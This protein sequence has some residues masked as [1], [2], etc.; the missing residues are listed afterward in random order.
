MADKYAVQSAS[1]Y[2]PNDAYVPVSVDAPIIFIAPS[3]LAAGSG[4][5]W[6]AVTCP[7]NKYGGCIVWASLNGSA[8]HRVGKMIGQSK[9]GGLRA[10]L[11][12]SS[13]TLDT[14]STLSIS[15]SNVSNTTTNPASNTLSSVSQQ[16]VDTAHSLCYVGGEFLAY[17][18]ATFVQYANNGAPWYDLTYLRRGLYGSSKSGVAQGVSF[19]FLNDAIFKYRFN[20]ELVGSNIDFKLQA[21]NLVEGAYQNIADCTAYS[22]TVS[23]SGGIKATTDDV[24]NA[25][26]TAVSGLK[27]NAVLN[28]SITG[29]TAGTVGSVRLPSGTYA[30]P[31]AMLGGQSSTHAAVLELRKISD[32]TLLATIGGAQGTPIWRTASAGFTLSAETDVKLML[33]GGASTTIASLYGLVV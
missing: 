14:A 29:T 4:E 18:T 17:K 9:K 26:N 21:F 25:V 11:P 2:A 7:D 30:A 5:I 13:T 15:L 3:A 24:S 16:S 19:V 27:I 10:A 28:S 12:S 6:M 31:S 8:Y 20:Q 23:S 33:R 22:F 1:G 32:D